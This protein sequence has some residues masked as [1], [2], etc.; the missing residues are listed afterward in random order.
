M[1]KFLF[2]TNSIELNDLYYRYGK[3]TDD[4]IRE[5][6]SRIKLVELDHKGPGTIYGYYPLAKGF[7]NKLMTKPRNLSWNMTDGR[8]TES[9][10]LKNLK[11]F[12]SVIYLVKST[13]RF[14]LKADLGEIFDQIDE[15]DL[16][17]TKGI[18]LLNDNKVIENT[19]GEHFLM[20]AILL[21]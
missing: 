8:E 14:I 2:P 3:V 7:I 11:A 12:K 21:K 17:E 6:L 9:K 16:S 20:S 5:H 19:E 1:D 15:Q 13:S 18:C 4:V 10:A